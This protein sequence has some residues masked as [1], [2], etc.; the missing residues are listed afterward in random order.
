MSHVYTTPFIELLEELVQTDMS[1]KNWNGRFT[2]MPSDKVYANTHRRALGVGSHASVK[3]HPTDPHMVKKHN[4]NPYGANT[5]RQYDGFNVFIQ[6]LIDNNLTDNIHFPKVYDL[7]TINDRDGN[8][9]HA[10]TMEKLVGFWNVGVDQVLSYFQNHF[11]P[12]VFPE[13]PD[14]ITKDDDKLRWFE[15]YV[16]DRM[17]KAIYTNAEIASTESLA[18]ALKIV[19]KA[20]RETGAA[21]DLGTENLMWRRSASGLVLVINDPLY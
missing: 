13:V 15:K 3:D 2:G 21:P 19:Y 5:R 20:R 8:R 7:K 10:Y 4:N 11:I 9:I 18:E 17:H 16:D 6:Y 12:G 1:Q 14:Y